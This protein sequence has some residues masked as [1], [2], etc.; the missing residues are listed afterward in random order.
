MFQLNPEL[1]E[2]VQKYNALL[3]NTN[4]NKSNVG[5]IYTGIAFLAI[6]LLFGLFTTLYLVEIPIYKKNTYIRTTL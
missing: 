6:G 3:S 2:V 4:L 5:L 1:L